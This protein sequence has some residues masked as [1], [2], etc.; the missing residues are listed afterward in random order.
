MED[1]WRKW[2]AT[3]EEGMEYTD[4]GDEK[5]L[6]GFFEGRGGLFVV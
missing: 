2:R 4:V 3:T 1:E 5:A 6:A